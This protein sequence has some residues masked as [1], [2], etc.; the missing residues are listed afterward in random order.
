[1]IQWLTDE[2]TLREMSD[3]DLLAAF[4]R[5]DGES[6]EAENLLREIERRELDF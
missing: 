4:Q 2:A 5:T 6:A 3:K 1:M